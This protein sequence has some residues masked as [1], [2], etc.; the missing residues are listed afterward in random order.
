MNDKLY[1]DPWKNI[2]EKWARLG[3]GNH[4][5]AHDLDLY[6][7][8]FLEAT[9]G[10]VSPQAVVFGATPELRDM[11]AR[12]N[13]QVTV[14]DI[15][16]NMIDAMGSYMK[17][18]HST[19]TKVEGNWLSPPFDGQS[20]H[21]V[22]GDQIKCNVAFEDLGQLYRE[23]ARVLVPGGY[24]ITRLTSRHSHTKIFDVEELIDMY[25]DKPPTKQTITELWNWLIF[26]THNNP[27]SSSDRMLDI[28]A[29]HASDPVI[30]E[31]YQQIRDIIPRGKVWTVG[32]SW[33]EER[34]KI[35]KYFEI[36]DQVQDDTLFAD[37]TYLYKM[38]KK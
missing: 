14:L 10:I 1:A 11:L 5:S 9:A 4:P 35:E 33:E 37:S 20:F 12:N 34:Q 25:R 18:S 28:L 24:H 22:F 26:Q 23:I 15:N 16:G 8:F 32:R 13:V 19:E 30:N 6:E 7:K 3:E 27:D 2:A 36:E 38:R 21:V 17:E 31:Y 29:N